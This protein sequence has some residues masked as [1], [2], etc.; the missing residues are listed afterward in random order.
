MSDIS[1]DHQETDN[2]NESRLLEAYIQK[3]EK[4]SFYQKGLEKMQQAGVFGFRW[5]WSWW[6]F[7]FG[8][9]F[10]LYRKA[11][12]PALG[13]FFF[14]AVLSIIPFGFLI[15]MIVVGGSA[16]YFILKRFNDLKN[17]LK[18]TEEERV[19]AMY[20]F[21]GFHTWVIWA[22]AIFYTLTFITAVVSL[23]VIGAAM[24]SGSP[25]GY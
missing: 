7:F 6:A 18:G 3:P 16:S 5:H 25:Y 22:A 17:T 13:A 19:K 11:Y 15:G 23:F 21:G 24:N 14:V 1:P 4:M 2:V 9:A 20:A 10:L 12:L 8:W